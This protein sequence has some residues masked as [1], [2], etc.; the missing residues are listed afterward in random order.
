MKSRIVLGILIPV[1]LCPGGCSSVRPI[2]LDPHFWQQQGKKIGV[3][4][5]TPPPAETTKL[6]PPTETFNT[7]APFAMNNEPWL[8][9][10][11]TEPLRLAEMKPL[12]KAMLKLDAREFHLVEDLFVSGLK[13]RGFSAFKVDQLVMRSY[14]PKFREWD[15]RR[16]YEKTDFRGLGKT[17]GADYLIVV[18]LVR[19]GPY[20]H[21][22]YAYND[23][24]AV[25]VQVRAE[26]IDARTN[27]IL[28]RT[29]GKKYDFSSP[30]NAS[31]G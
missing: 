21:Y 30:V 14:F 7:S 16:S 6:A 8:E 17:Y 5:L 13:R 31:C 26:L 29:G 28:W 9:D 12:Q 20:C 19:Y 24:M 18:D 23:H 3:V 11:V 4:L 1:L 22:V 10:M 15:M 27:R 25:E 2:P